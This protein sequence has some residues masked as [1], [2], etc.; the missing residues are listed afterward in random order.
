M[1]I[2][3]LFSFL[4]MFFSISIA[5]GISPQTFN[6]VA[7]ASIIQPIVAIMVNALDGKP[8]K[9]TI[10]ISPIRP[11]PGIPDITTP[12]A[13]AMII[14]IMYVEIPFV[15]MLNTLNKK[16]I[17]KIEAIA[18]PSMCIVAPSGNETLL[19]LESIFI[20]SAVSKFVGKLAR[21][22]CVAKEH[23]TEGKIFL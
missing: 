21:E 9:D 20:F 2:H 11:P 23:I 14:A 4:Y 10:N 1:I 19:T 16:K 17:F 15:G 18:E 22:D 5:L 8:Y 13:T 7:G 3:F 12:L 6:I